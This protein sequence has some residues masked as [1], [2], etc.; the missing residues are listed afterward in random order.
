MKH[1][2]SADGFLYRLRPVKLSDARFIIDTRL[3]DVERN[4]FIHK[5][6]ADEDSQRQWISDYLQRQGD[7]YFVIENKLTKESEGLIGF[8]NEKDGSAEWGRWV[9]KKNSLA[10]VESVDL[11]YQIAFEQIGLNELY[12]RTLELNE[13]V[14]SFHNSIGEKVRGI[15]ENQ[16]EIDGRNYNAIEHYA[17]KSIFYNEIKPLL[18]KQS[19]MLFKR[20]IKKLIGDLEFHHIGVATNDIEKELRTFYLL[21]YTKEGE[22]FEDDKQGIKGLFIVAKNQPRLELLA[23]LDGSKTVSEFL[24]RN[25]KLY[26]F[27][28]ITQNIQAAYDILVNCKAHV[29]SPMKMS[30]YFGKRICFLLMPNRFIVELI[31]K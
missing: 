24:D 3:E 7:Y 14:V 9:I 12:C 25:N 27:G 18:D 2:Y 5:I 6:S 8:Y 30:E 11:M 13:S 16:F 19:L 29:L 23:N 17:D 10:A 31:E 26:H 22:I 21:G 28:Y 1:N 20:A 15:S 4:K